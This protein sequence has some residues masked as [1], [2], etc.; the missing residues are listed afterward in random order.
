ME[1]KKKGI[2]ALIIAKAK[3]KQ[4][5]GG[6]NVDGM[7]VAVEDMM[8]ALD[9]RDPAMFKAALNAFLDHR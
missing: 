8:Q 9:E 6:D 2:A 5:E 3:P 4:D 1:N 7:D